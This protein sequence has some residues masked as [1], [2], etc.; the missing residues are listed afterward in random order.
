MLLQVLQVDLALP[1]SVEKAFLARGH[2]LESSRSVATLI[3]E[4][5]I[6]NSSAILVLTDGVE[7]SIATVRD[8]CKALPD[9]AIMVLCGDRET[10]KFAS[11]L[12]VGADDVLSIDSCPEEVHA[13]VVTIVCR[14]MGFSPPV[15]ELFGLQLNL[16]SRTVHFENSALS[17]SDIEFQFLEY[18]VL[19]SITDGL[20][21]GSVEDSFCSSLDVKRNEIEEMCHSFVNHLKMGGKNRP[22]KHRI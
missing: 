9:K 12:N 3:N 15:V 10:S 16:V 18:L 13:R 7:V 1:S 19:K 20:K 4:F 21:S 17:L 8:L 2:V 22:F 6:E 14:K 11:F 5:A